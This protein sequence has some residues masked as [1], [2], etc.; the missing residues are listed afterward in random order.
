MRA[1]GVRGVHEMRDAAEEYYNTSSDV[2]PLFGI[3]QFRRRR[4]VIKLV[5]ENTSLLFKGASPTWPF[6]CRTDRSCTARVQVHWLTITTRFANHDLA[7]E[8]TKPSEL[9]EHL[10]TQHIELHSG[11]SSSGSTRKPKLDGIEE[12]AED[13]EE[14]SNP[15]ERL[16]D[17][18]LAP[19]DVPNQSLEQSSHPPEATSAPSIEP[20]TRP[21]IDTASL[22]ERS[23]RLAAA[24][25]APEFKAPEVTEKSPEP[26]HEERKETE[27]KEYAV[28]VT[29]YRFDV[30]DEDD[31]SS[32]GV[33][34]FEDRR[35]SS[36]MARPS[37]SDQS[38]YSSL[39]RPKVKGRPTAISGEETAA[40]ED[41]RASCSFSAG[42]YAS[43]KTQ[44]LGGAA[45][46]QRFGAGRHAHAA[47]SADTGDAQ[48]PTAAAGRG[49]VAPA[50]N[51]SL[52][53]F[54]SRPV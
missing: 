43:P 21:H 40:V 44:P 50:S 10:L 16:V 15:P 25:E 47:P 33:Y 31:D 32:D 18:A 28:S 7:Y 8:I 42:R 1:Q 14:A 17:E 29:S 4:V 34:E 27:P 36:Q 11:R 2:K 51:P 24:L 9:D 45:E 48:S 22:I 20:L 41:R 37:T 26:K 49:R 52:R 3:T 5:P 23:R 35:T 6:D 46:V 54:L 12:D 39:F 30:D 38:Y 13:A 53:R 19:Q